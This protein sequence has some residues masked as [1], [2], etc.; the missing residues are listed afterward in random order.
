MTMSRMLLAGVVVMLS[1]FAGSTSHAASLTFAYEGTIDSTF[2][3]PDSAPFD[4]FLGETLRVEYTFE[5]T[6][7]DNN[8]SS[9]G[10]YLGAVTAAE[11]VL[12]SNVYTATGGNI[13][14]INN[15]INPDQYIVDVLIGLAGPAVGGLP[16]VRFEVIFSDTTHTFFSSDALPTVQ[17]DPSGFTSTALQFTFRSLSG[18]EDGVIQA[19]TV[20]ISEPKLVPSL[21]PLGLVLLS[22]LLVLIAG[23][24]T[25]RVVGS[26]PCQSR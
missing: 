1:S 2:G 6:T 25:R 4:A 22:A 14:I 7:P 15:D 26:R 9:N 5:T 13:I 12:G 8:S 24:L 23:R 16:P 21:G 11:I 18:E 3:F 19:R 17:P 20:V 10:D